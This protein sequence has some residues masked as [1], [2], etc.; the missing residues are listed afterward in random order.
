MKK[1]KIIVFSL[2]SVFIS[3]F[4]FLLMV[5]FT[6]IPIIRK[7]SVINETNEIFYVTPLIKQGVS[8][9]EIEEL[10]GE[11]K[12]H[13]YLE[14]IDWMRVLQQYSFFSNP[15]IPAF[16][17]KDIR[18]NPNSRIELYI[19]YEEIKQENGPKIL[20]IKDTL[21]NYFYKHAWFF[22]TDTIKSKRSLSISPENIVKEKDSGGDMFGVQIMMMILS[23]TLIILFPYLLIKSIKK[24]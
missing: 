21:G 8:L 22:G 1:I 14:Q 11:N 9:G 2:L 5:G 16:T 13:E 10:R 18:L 19:D 4:V 12:M 24:N 20:L 7:Y 3:G 23:I 15:A 6:M 17:D